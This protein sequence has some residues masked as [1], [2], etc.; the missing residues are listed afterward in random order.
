MSF[1]TLE[2]AWGLPRFSAAAA[3]AAPAGPDKGS[4]AAGHPN[5][6]GHANRERGPTNRRHRGPVADADVHGPAT[7][8][9][10]SGAAD[11]LAGSRN[12]GTDDVEVQN[13]RRFL[14]RT[15]ARF[16][17]PGLMRLMPHRAVEEMGGVGGRGRHGPGAKLWNA[18]L[19]ALAHPETL[20][21]L[22]LCAFAAVVTWDAL[23]SEPCSS[24]LAPTMTSLHMSPF[25]LGTSNL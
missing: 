11:P 3:A 12:E 2:E 19:R 14:A 10:P 18:L 22:L 4:P 23:K 1:A 25:P 13:A 7:W 17:V 20:L 8:S 6:A 9:S 21:F 16:G 5:P 15:Y 24:S